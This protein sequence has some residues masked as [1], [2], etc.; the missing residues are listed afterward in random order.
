MIREAARKYGARAVVLVDEYDKPI[1]DNIANPEVAAQM[2]EGLKN[3]YSALK[4][5][6]AHLQFVFMT[7]VS[8]FSKVSLFSGVNQLEDITLDTH[9]S[10][11]CGYTQGDLEA[12]FKEHLKGVEWEKSSNGITGIN[13]WAMKACI[14]PMIFCC[15]SKKDVN[16]ATTGSRPAIPAF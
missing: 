16:T 3:L 5:Q 14:I 7:G 13:G 2:R 1:L 8:K 12:S 15:S 10:T 6:D 9:Y 11:I 4:G